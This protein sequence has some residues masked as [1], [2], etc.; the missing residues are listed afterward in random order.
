M[1]D[2]SYK[3]FSDK[4]HW[5]ASH[6]IYCHVPLISSSYSNAFSYL[7]I[8]FLLFASDFL[9]FLYLPKMPTSFTLH[10]TNWFF[11]PQFRHHIICLNILYTSLLFLSILCSVQ[12]HPTHIFVLSKSINFYIS[13]Q[14]QRALSKIL[15]EEMDNI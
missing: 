11:N 2:M 5:L 1:L 3:V 12:I 8:F 6:H 14:V 13:I 7:N 9:T 10:L 4:P 15:K